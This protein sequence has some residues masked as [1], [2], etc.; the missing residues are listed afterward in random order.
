M[1]VQEE[2]NLSGAENPPAPQVPSHLGTDHSHLGC[3]LSS[4]GFK[5]VLKSCIFFMWNAVIYS[6]GIWPI[7]GI[8]CL[9]FFMNTSPIFSAV[10]CTCISFV[11]TRVRYSNAFCLN[12]IIVSSVACFVKQ[13]NKPCVYRYLSCLKIVGKNYNYGLW[14][15]FHWFSRTK[16]F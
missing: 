1:E 12:L 8:W 4:G 2:L 3:Q 13:E 16:H 15:F 10:S 7:L 9:M 11:F 6:S 5:P 14:G